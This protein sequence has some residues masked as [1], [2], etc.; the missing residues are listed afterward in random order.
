MK[1]KKISFWGSIAS[2]IGLVFAVYSL[3]HPETTSR[4]TNPESIITTGGSGQTIANINGTQNINNS[5]PTLTIN[6][7]PKIPKFKGE[8]GHYQK[9]KAFIDFISKNQ[10]EKVLIDASYSPY[11]PDDMNDNFR[12]DYL[13]L[14]KNCFE[15]LE[16]NEEPSPLKCEGVGFSIDRSNSPKDAYMSYFRGQLKI[17]G[18]FAI[19]GCSGPHQ[20]SMGCT[21]RPLNPESD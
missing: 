20:G 19:K 8:I 16:T 17:K 5:G 7:E 1:M 12:I 2:I 10:G 15:E 18:Y 11:F 13:H 21:L 3:T 9:S 14:W 4:N 6:P